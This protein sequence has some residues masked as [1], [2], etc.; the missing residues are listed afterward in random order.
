MKI[1]NNPKAKPRQKRGIYKELKLALVM[2]IEYLRGCFRYR[3][4]SQAITVFGS[5]RFTPEHPYSKHA[6]DS[7]ASPQNSPA[8]S[9]HSLNSYLP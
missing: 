1:P 5:A 9:L 3:K 8:S 2:T 6:E 7:L 4:L